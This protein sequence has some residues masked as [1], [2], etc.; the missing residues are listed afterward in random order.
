MNSSLFVAHRCPVSL[1]LNVCE[2]LTLYWSRG[3]CSAALPRFY[4]PTD[5]CVQRSE[6]HTGG[7]YGLGSTY[8]ICTSDSF[9]TPLFSQLFGVQLLPSSPLLLLT[10]SRKSGTKTKLFDLL[11]DLP[12]VCILCLSLVGSVYLLRGVEASEA[13][14]HP[15]SGHLEQPPHVQ[16]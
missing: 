4:N 9:F 7:F 3:D 6:L 11:Q 12:F 10:S 1:H 5:T 14:G 15:G 13:V 8:S 16:A 2:C